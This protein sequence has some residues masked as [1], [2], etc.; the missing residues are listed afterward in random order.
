M[1][2]PAVTDK[3]HPKT[4]QLL[5]RHLSQV[6]HGAQGAVVGLARLLAEG[7]EGEVTIIILRGAGIRSFKTT[8]SLTGDTIKGELE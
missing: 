5:E 3:L 6:P 8:N 1:S 4:L 7:F 2:L